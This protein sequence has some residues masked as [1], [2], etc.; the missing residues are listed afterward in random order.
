MTIGERISHARKERK[1]KQSDLARILCVSP[2]TIGMYEQNR[3]EPDIGTLIEI[4]KCLNVSVEYL[5]GLDNKN[6]NELSEPDKVVLEAVTRL[7]NN[8]TPTPDYGISENMIVFNLD[9]QSEKKKLT[10]EQMI[11]LKAMLDALPDTPTDL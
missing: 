11:M 1:L 10:R 9:G 8:D 3:R 6:K 4:A 2:S 7:S 5:L